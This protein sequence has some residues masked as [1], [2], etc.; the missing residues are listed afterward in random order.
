MHGTLV[1]IRENVWTPNFFMFFF[2]SLL[3]CQWII[4]LHRFASLTVQHPRNNNVFLSCIINFCFPMVSS[5]RLHFGQDVESCWTSDDGEVKIEEWDFFPDGFCFYRVSD[6]VASWHVT[7]YT[8]HLSHLSHLSH[9]PYWLVQVAW[10]VGRFLLLV[11]TLPIPKYFRFVCPK[12]RICRFLW[13]LFVYFD[14]SIW[15]YFSWV[16]EVAS[17]Y[18]LLICNKFVSFLLLR[19]EHFFTTLEE[20]CS[21]W[22]VFYRRC[23][24]SLFAAFPNTFCTPSGNLLHAVMWCFGATYNFW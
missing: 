1:A 15:P 16:S 12:T 8:P 3:K 6:H 23:N 9:L 17:N 7:W 11:P 21:N 10:G 5:V 14:H 22:P 18:L 4:Y 20:T 19:A 2:F 13:G 24:V